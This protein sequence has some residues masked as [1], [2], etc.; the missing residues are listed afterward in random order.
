MEFISIVF[1]GGIFYVYKKSEFDSK[2]TN[3]TRT[4]VFLTF[5]AG[6]KQK[7]MMM[8]MMMNINVKR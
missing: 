2:I 5:M 7:K 3:Y 1:R 8:M 4:S 6:T